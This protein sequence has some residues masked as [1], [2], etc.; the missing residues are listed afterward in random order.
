VKMTADIARIVANKIK[1]GFANKFLGIYNS[2]LTED[3]FT[4]EKVLSCLKTDT[5]IFKL[6]EK[7]DFPVLETAPPYDETPAPN[8]KWVAPME[9]VREYVQGF[10]P[11]DPYDEEKDQM[12]ITPLAGRFEVECGAVVYAKKFN[13]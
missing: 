12:I 3:D 1:I 11:I 13:D 2:L 5:E 4:P 10:S 6:V 8:L 9:L 7:D